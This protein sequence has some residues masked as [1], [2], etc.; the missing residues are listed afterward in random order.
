M[1]YQFDTTRL[2]PATRITAA[3]NAPSV[4]L[5]TR[6]VARQQRRAIRAL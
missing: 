5:L 4:R 1:S 6:R 2:Q 3:S